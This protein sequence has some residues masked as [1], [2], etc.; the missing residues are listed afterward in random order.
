M[1]KLTQRM[2]W[3]RDVNIVLVIWCRSF[4]TATHAS[5]QRCNK[6]HLEWCKRDV[7]WPHI[8][9]CSHD[10]CSARNSCCIFYHPISV[11]V[12]LHVIYI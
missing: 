9:R 8:S 12:L 11:A 7:S 1:L 3:N 6:V 5:R 10:R 4:S 2:S